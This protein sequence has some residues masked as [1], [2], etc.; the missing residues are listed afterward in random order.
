[1]QRYLTTD[2]GIELFPL[3]SCC[4]MMALSTTGADPQDDTEKRELLQ[5][6]I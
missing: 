4:S 6:Q 2:P 1:M 3:K 5:D